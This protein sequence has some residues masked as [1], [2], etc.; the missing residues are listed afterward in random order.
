[1]KPL[2]WLLL[3]LA[4]AN[5]RTATCDEKKAYLEFNHG[6]DRG[7]AEWIQAITISAPAPRSEIEGDVEVKFNA[8][9]MIAAKALCWQ[10]PTK[11]QPGEWGH[12]ENLTPGGIALDA[13]GEGSFIF[14]AD[15]FPNGPANI[16]IFAESRE[17]RKD[18]YEL[19]LFNRGGVKWKQG[20]PKQDPPGAKGLKRIFAD[21]FDAAL[22]ISNDGRGT[23]YAAHKPR[24]GD[25]SGWQFSDV[26]GEGKPFAQTGTWLKIAA[27]KDETSPK[28]RSGLISSVN[29]DG[30]GVWAKAPAYLECRFTAQSAPGTWPAFWTITHLDQKSNGDELDIVE[31]YGGN[32]T[33]HP[34]HP[35]YSIVTHPWGQKNSDGTEKPHPN[36]VVRMME[37][38]GKSY[39]SS[40][41]HTYAVSIGLEDT[42]YYLDDIE[43][44]RHPTND[45]SKKH[46]HCFLINYAIGGI[47]GWPIDLE[48]YGNGTDMYVD[49]V[50]VYAKE[51]IPDYVLPPPGSRPEITTRGIGLNLSVAGDKSTELAPSETAGAAGVSQTAW[52]NLPGA[53][54]RAASLK[55]SDGELAEGIAASWEVMGG[56][57]AGRSKAG[58]EWGFSG[59]HL[60]MQRGYIQGVGKLAVSGIRYPRYEVHVYVNADD[61]G[62]SGRVSLQASGRQEHRHYKLGWHEGK[63]IESAGTTAETA[64]GGNYVV[65][66]GQ[67]AREFALEWDGTLAGGQTGASGIQIVEVP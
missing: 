60:G 4:L 20:I 37:L 24:Y 9:G 22:S 47:S 49:Y 5:P 38:G 23:R 42:V 18:I 41:F 32:G 43:V 45:V 2:P 57:Q 15:R 56:D 63:F 46:P 16:R 66:R 54:G 26:L 27:R 30:K 62:G 64:A 36:T 40:T 33:G 12:D 44:F 35:G 7:G 21:D 50:R 3:L 1:M 29:M 52:N 11:E 19:Q 61:N 13:S 59:G 25:F 10:Q 39:W 67:T 14:P 53:S 55:D 8:K 65:F 51:A 28:G 58:R 48:R 17:G 34:N 31:A 6:Q